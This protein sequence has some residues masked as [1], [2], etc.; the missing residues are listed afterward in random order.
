MHVQSFIP[1]MGTT[2]VPYVIWH[3][4][5]E[6]KNYLSKSNMAIIMVIYL[7]FLILFK[8]K[9]FNNDDCT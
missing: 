9:K 2:M 8:I 3:S 5:I 4:T 6:L 7:F 1:W